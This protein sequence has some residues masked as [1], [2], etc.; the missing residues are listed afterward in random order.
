M[1]NLSMELGWDGK[2][3]C[4]MTGTY[5]PAHLLQHVASDTLLR[6]PIHQFIDRFFNDVMEKYA[7]G[8][9]KSQFEEFCIKNNCQY[10]GATE[11]LETD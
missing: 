6:A 1:K 11:C 4:P 2:G 5:D 10:N 9:C 7:I 3:M 8:Y